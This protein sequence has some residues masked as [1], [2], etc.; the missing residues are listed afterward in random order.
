VQA[1]AAVKNQQDQ[2]KL[3]NMSR[4]ALNKHVLYHSLKKILSLG[5]GTTPTVVV[6]QRL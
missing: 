3:K 1:P 4:V 2:K 6:A 5:A